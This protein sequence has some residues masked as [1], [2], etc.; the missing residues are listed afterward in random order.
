M[1]IGCPSPQPLSP[2]AGER[3]RGEGVAIEEGHG[4][5]PT[6]TSHR[7]GANAEETREVSIKQEEFLI[8]RGV[9]CD[10]RLRKADVSRHH[11]IIRFRS[12]DVS[13][14]DL[15]SSNGTYLNGQRVR[16]QATLHSGDVLRVGESS[17]VID[18]GDREPVDLGVVDVD[19]IAST[20]VMPGPKNT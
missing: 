11:C 13:L 12:D 10:L 1:S 5:V 4:Y 19:P 17:F 3:G 2:A 14:L 16:S 20:R 9:D 8:G 15:G 6:G 18:L 7:R